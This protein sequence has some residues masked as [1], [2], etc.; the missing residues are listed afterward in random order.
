MV[1]VRPFQ[2]TGLPRY[3]KQQVALYES[4]ATY[5]SYRPYRPDFRDSLETL[6][7][8][9][10]KAP[11]GLARPELR[12][13]SRAEMGG[14]LPSLG[15]FVVVGAAPGE[16]KI[17]LDMDPALASMCIERLLGGHGEPQ[18]RLQR[19][20]T[21]IETGVLSFV[22]LKALAH[23]G[24]GWQNGRELALTLDR[25]AAK[26]SELAPIIDAETGY[27]QLGV[28]VELAKRTAYVRIFLPDALVQKRFGTP[29]SQS[30]GTPRELAY[31]R[32]RLKHLGEKT[33]SARVVA[34]TLDLSGDD[35]ANV[36][37]G[38][39]IVL[40]N[41]QLQK[42]AD[43]ID[44]RVFV[45]LGPGENG[46]FV[47]QLRNEA[48]QA[49]LEV[50]EIINQE[51]PLEESMAESEQGDN[52]PE[53]QGLLRDVDASVVVELGR[54]RMNTAQVVRLRQGQILRLPRGPNDPVDLVVNGK[55]FARGELIEVEGELGVRLVAVTG[56][57]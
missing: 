30:G 7:A 40:E 16:H 15:C 54:I 45:R 33:I 44:G 42:T 50:A 10:L 52:L 28:R 4:L 23:F 26:P 6:L 5:L 19:P 12:S 32:E 1:S 14:L 18:A 22:V 3:T 38:D 47:G 56:A 36:E 34:T 35:I 11:V 55:L 43:G 27:Q 21:D 29:V 53:T 37:P 48:D 39:I 46:G 31:M 49:R 2:F 13:V 9:A 24:E 41:H 20:L 25:F 8:A 17:L 57:E 51:Q